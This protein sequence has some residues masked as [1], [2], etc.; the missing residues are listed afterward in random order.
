MCLH[1][2]FLQRLVSPETEFEVEI[3][4]QVTEG[5]LSGVKEIGKKDRKP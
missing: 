1:R 3:F 5:V 2:M 4:V